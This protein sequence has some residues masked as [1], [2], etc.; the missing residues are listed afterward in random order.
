MWV[1]ISFRDSFKSQES[2]KHTTTSIVKTSNQA[3]STV[4]IVT[5]TAHVFNPSAI[6]PS[7]VCDRIVNDSGPNKHEDEGRQETNTFDNRTK[8]N[9]NG[10]GSEL[11]LIQGKDNHWDLR[12]STEKGTP[13]HILKAAISKVTENHGTAFGKGKGESKENPLDSYNRVGQEANHD[14]GQCIL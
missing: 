9:G 1:K 13:R 8:D 6:T 11:H 5:R 12:S 7:P 10:D 4:K 3:R 14:D 2:R